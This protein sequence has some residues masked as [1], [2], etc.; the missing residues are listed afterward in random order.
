[1]TSLALRFI[2]D[3]LLKKWPKGNNEGKSEI[4]K[5]KYLEIE[6]SFLDEIKSIFI[7]VYG[8]AFVE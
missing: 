4:Q 6:K 5:F 2:F 1:M 7:I 3:Y 8:L